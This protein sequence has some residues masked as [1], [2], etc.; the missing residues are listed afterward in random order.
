MIVRKAAS[1]DLPAILAIYNEII[2]NSTAIY[3]LHPVDL[4]ERTAW[5]ESRRADGMP[6]LVAEDDAEVVGFSSFGSWRG[7]WAGYRHTV[8]HSVHVRA[9]RRGGGVGR[10][11]M[12]ALLPL[13]RVHGKH[14]MIGGVDADNA[15]SLRFHERLG[16]TKVA[17]F[18]EV[19][20][21]FDR[22]LDLVFVQ[23][24]LDAPGKPRP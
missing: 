5:F 17:H 3:A 11:L 21:K 12:E 13:A 23:R 4:A 8:E 20:Q 24:M 1:S 19:G 14:V 9:D 10:R 16:F 7:G 6:V 2:A 18:R 22:W 15:A